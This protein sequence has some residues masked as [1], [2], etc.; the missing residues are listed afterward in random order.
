M[1]IN[2]GHAAIMYWLL[3]QYKAETNDSRKRM[4]MFGGGAVI[5]LWLFVMPQFKIDRLAFEIDGRNVY[6]SEQVVSDEI[7]SVIADHVDF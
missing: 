7:I 5:F 2:Y 3:T 1:I 4:I 6:T